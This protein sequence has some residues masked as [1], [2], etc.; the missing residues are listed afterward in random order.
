MTINVSSDVESSIVEAV[1]SGRFPSVDEAVAAAWLAFTQ[2]QA[3]PE[4]PSADQMTIAPV[5]KPIWEVAAEI[6]KSIPAEEWAKLPTDGAAQLDHYL[7][8]SAKRP[9][10]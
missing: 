7:H 1:R 8:G 3:P 10:T 9:T 5:Y 2:T 4:P 6:R